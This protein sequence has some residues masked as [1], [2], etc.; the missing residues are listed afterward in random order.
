MAVVS[1]RPPTMVYSINTCTDP[2][3][4]HNSMAVR[5]A[6][7]VYLDVAANAHIQ[8]ESLSRKRF[9]TTLLDFVGV[10]IEVG[11]RLQQE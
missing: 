5:Q 6:L 7:Y 4:M 10:Y 8:T 9:F 1:W 2:L 3:D 11:Q